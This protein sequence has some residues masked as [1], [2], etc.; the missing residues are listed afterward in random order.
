MQVTRGVCTTYSPIPGS[1]R[2][3]S[4]HCLCREQPKTSGRHGK[5]CGRSN[6][7]R[8]SAGCVVILK[9]L[10]LLGNVLAKQ[11]AYEAGCFEA[12]LHRDGIVTEGSSSNMFGVKDG[13]VYTHPA[14]NL[15]LNGITRQVVLGL[16]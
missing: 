10:N 7:L 8:M 2:T 11:E 15:I 1:D 6:L 13:T 4:C 14:T 12:L 9:V 5:W 16:M 3:T